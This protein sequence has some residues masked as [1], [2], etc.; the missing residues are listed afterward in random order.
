MREED[1]GV[2]AAVVDHAQR[3]EVVLERVPDDDGAGV[4]EGVHRLA[5]RS[6]REHRGRVVFLIDA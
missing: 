1:G 3:L 5:D 2:D 6:E 4:D